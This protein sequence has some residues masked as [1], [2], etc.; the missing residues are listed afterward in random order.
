MVHMARVVDSRGAYKI[1]MRRSERRRPFERQRC[2]REDNRKMHPKFLEGADWTY[3][4]RTVR[5][6]RRLITGH[7]ALGSLK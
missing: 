2:R 3:L 4:V 7:V 6:Y 1:L 5:S